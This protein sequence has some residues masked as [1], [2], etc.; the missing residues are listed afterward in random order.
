M[1]FQGK[2]G[3]RLNK[4]VDD[5]IIILTFGKM[6]K[7]IGYKRCGRIKYIKKAGIKQRKIGKILCFF[8]VFC[9]DQ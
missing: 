2:L 7:A 8:T 6:A 9:H 4:F 3:G 1:D 5:Y